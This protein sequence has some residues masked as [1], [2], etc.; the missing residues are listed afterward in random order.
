[1]TSTA[2][3]PA[4]AFNEQLQT[5]IRSVLRHARGELRAWFDLDALALS[6]LALATFYFLYKAIDGN[7]NKL[8]GEPADDYLLVLPNAGLSEA[9][10]Q[11][12]LLGALLGKYRANYIASDAPAQVYAVG[13][14]LLKPLRN[15]GYKWYQV[16]DVDAQGLI[17]RRSEAVRTQGRLPQQAPTYPG[18]VHNVIR[19]LSRQQARVFALDKNYPTKQLRADLIRAIDQIGLYVRDAPLVSAYPHRMGVVCTSGT[20]EFVAQVHPMP[21]RDWSTHNNPRMMLPLEP[22]AETARSYHHLAQNVFYQRGS[23]NRVEEL[24]VFDTRQYC[25][26]NGRFAELLQGR[27]QGFYRN[28]VLVGSR[29]PYTPDGHT[30]HR[31]RRWEW[32]PEELALLLGQQLRYPQIEVVPDPTLAALHAKALVDWKELAHQHG[33]DLSALPRLLPRLYSLVLPTDADGTGEA[34]RQGAGL[35]QW[36]ENLLVQDRVLSNAHIYDPT[37]VGALKANIGQSLADVARRLAEHNGKF[38]RLRELLALTDAATP[39]VLLVGRRELTFTEAA[40]QAA[41]SA[42]ELRRLR[43]VDGSRLQ[44]LLQDRAL[45]RADVTW[46]VASLRLGGQHEREL[47]TYRRLLLARASVRLLAYDGVDLARYAQLAALHQRLVAQALSHPDRLW[48]VGPELAAPLSGLP[49]PA[50]NSPAASDAPHTPTAALPTDAAAPVADFTAVEEVFGQAGN[51]SLSALPTDDDWEDEWE[52]SSS[53]PG[54]KCQLYFTDGSTLVAAYG[55]LVDVSLPTPT[56][57]MLGHR[58]PGTL[59]PGDEVLTLRADRGRL[60]PYL[61]RS[62]PAKFADVDAASEC[63]LNALW[64]LWHHFRYSVPALHSKLKAHGLRLHVGTL[65]RWLQSNTETRFPRRAANLKAIARLETEVFGADAQ[66]PARF[67]QVLAQR[68]VY[69]AA[70]RLAT[71]N[72][73]LLLFEAYLSQDQTFARTALGDNLFE[74]LFN[75]IQA[76]TFERLRLL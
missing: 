51:G 9:A 63:W 54:Q 38:V 70:V 4:P 26:G 15:G 12:A 30:P 19:L 49:G 17:R 43:V 68:R 47:S 52:D 55:R 21:L 44:H 20:A 24:L 2:T 66:L 28:L 74:V 16:E 29:A 61:R 6:D 46:V 36:T 75:S 65:E 22:M 37:L 18:P 60:L 69:N 14:V 73:Q 27:N 50:L 45:N 8:P 3:L 67:S 31:F 1:M 76:R 34:T 72:S 10:V 41:L 11:G 64:Q 59:V 32:T 33:L 35:R 56:G 62:E 71:H 5:Y 57:P 42:D 7:E 58:L 13:D 39:V 25:D 23:Y 40:L 48:F 53:V